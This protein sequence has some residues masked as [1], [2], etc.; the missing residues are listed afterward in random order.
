MKDDPRRIDLPREGTWAYWTDMPEWYLRDARSSVF[1]RMVNGK[2]QRYNP[3]TELERYEIK[4]AG[5]HEYPTPYIIVDET[6]TV[7]DSLGNP[8]LVNKLCKRPMTD[9]YLK[10][11]KW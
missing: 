10:E 8:M 11:G 2:P 6:V 3:S 1:V 9:K 5:P 7:F 4:N